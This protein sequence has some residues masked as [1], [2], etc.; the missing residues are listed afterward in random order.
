MMM[1]RHFPLAMVLAVMMIAALSAPAWAQTDGDARLGGGSDLPPEVTIRLPQGG[2]IPPV[3]V[4]F[5]DNPTDE[6][7]DVEFRAEA[8]EGIV[9][10]PE[11]E[12]ETI[13]AR[14]SVENPFWVQ[15]A[16]GA[17]PGEYP[18]VVQLVRSDIESEP[19]NITSIPAIQAAFT[20]EVTGEAATVTV[21]SVSAHSGDPVAA[22]ITL[23]ARHAEHEWFEIDRVEGT[24]LESQVAPG[25]FR[26]A[27]LLGE[28][29]VAA[30]EFTVEA[31]Q[32][33]DVAIEVET[34]SFVVAAARPV[35]ERGRLVVADLV[36]SVNNETEPISGDS[37]LQATV[38]HDGV[39]VDTVTLEELSE[40]PTGITDAAVT[41]RPEGGW[42][43]GNYRFLFELVTPAFVLAA[44]D[45]PILEVP[46]MG[47]DLLPFLAGLDTREAIALAAVAVLVLL[48]V[49]RLIRFLLRRRRSNRVTT[50]KQR[51]RERA[52]GRRPR[53]F[54]RKGNNPPPSEPEGSWLEERIGPVTTQRS[55]WDDENPER[56]PHTS[57]FAPARVSGLPPTVPPAESHL[58][59]TG[60]A[61]PDPEPSSPPP[62]GSTPRVPEGHS[63]DMTHMVEALRV[64]Q[65]LHDEG[66]LA[67]D[68]S[69]TDATLIYWA[70]I[71]PQVHD[72]L[73][74][75]G[76]SE[77]EYLAA[78][79]KLFTHGLVD[80]NNHR[81]ISDR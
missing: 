28:R 69:I 76:M 34:V 13:P 14:G 46:A 50:R 70:M 59:S 81:G 42:Q 33:L 72:A 58:A 9:I 27:V 55:R 36:A 30:E 40:V 23:A 49:E 65:R 66:K 52:D 47:F 25:E 7:I 17:A 74:S 29:E 61:T 78:M 77:E 57:P 3:H 56:S 51:R 32:N 10:D 73:G 31:D 2:S 12:E 67:P 39:E 35:T 48:L 54:R 75:V 68:W 20:V 6:A 60:E 19:G 45:Q 1:R 62:S 21:R 4:I 8:P 53:R 5:A 64:V 16:P 18:V 11:W 79:R 24:T 63:G 15:V 71:S 43:E 22:T 41:Y 80:Q 26:A 44:P 38:S 37:V